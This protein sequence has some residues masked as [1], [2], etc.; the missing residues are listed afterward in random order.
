MA[1]QL[2]RVDDAFEIALVL[3]DPIKLRQ[4]GDLALT[5]GR[6]KIS[7]QAFEA[8]EDLGGLLLIFTSLGLKERL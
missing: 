1:L 8:A 3:N 2:Q 6:I 5:E 4:V 7:V